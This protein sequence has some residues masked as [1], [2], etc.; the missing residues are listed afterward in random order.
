MV[1]RIP[2]KPLAL[3][4]ALTAVMLALGSLA[5]LLGLGLLT[6][7]VSGLSL[8]LIGAGGVGIPVVLGLWLASRPA[9]ALELKL[10][11]WTWLSQVPEVYRVRGEVV[12]TNHNPTLEVTLAEVMPEIRLL[13]R[14]SLGELAVT[15]QLVGEQAPERRD[16]YWPATILS[17][18]S[19]LKLS[20]EIQIQGQGLGELQSLW[21]QLHY[22]QYGRQ[23]RT[24]KTLH[25][26]L[27]M[28][29]PLPAPSWRQREG[30]GVLPLPTHL[31]T[32]T[33]DL[34]EVVRTYAG[35]YAQAG[36]Y[37]ALAES[38]VAITQGRFRHPTA[39]RLGWLAPKLCY[40]F[41]SKTSLSSAYGMQA[42]IDESGAWRVVL[43]FIVGTLAKALGIKGVFYALA[44]S[45]AP[46]IDDVT[47]TLPP[48]D[49]FLVLGPQQPQAVVEQLATTCGYGMAIVDVNDLREVKVLAA[50]RGVDL[51]TLTQALRDNPGGN[52][53]EQTP[54]VLIRPSGTPS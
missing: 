12:A 7:G 41:P 25:M 49:Q 2:V 11:G 34:Q 53:D 45:Q 38:A 52:A 18:Q 35:P 5:L 19:Q 46:L 31:L 29:T 8:G 43:A 28:P 36:D 47:G 44:G 13:S 50:S 14:G 51:A 4:N 16:N 23:R 42:L 15:W 22:I 48:Y 30:I 37:L 54:L 3:I 40:C 6:Q 26:I 17:P 27:A 20:L 33:D 24:R 32:P 1:V 9:D 10:L 21:C 39:I